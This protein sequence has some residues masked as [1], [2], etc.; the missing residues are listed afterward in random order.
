MFLL[1]GAGAIC[2]RGLGLKGRLPAR[3]VRPGDCTT[4][5]ANV[6][7][8]AHV[9]ERSANGAR[10]PRIGN[11]GIVPPVAN[12][13][14]PSPRDPCVPP[15]P[16][17]PVPPGPA[18]GAQCVVDRGPP[19]VQSGTRS[20]CGPLVCTV[21]VPLFDLGCCPRARWEAPPPISQVI[22]RRVPTTKSDGGNGTQGPVGSGSPSV[23][24]R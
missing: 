5:P 17:P 10:G 15:P 18:P 6:G 8:V 4:N 2:C 9:F 22:P 21:H 12:P 3:S 11:I 13:Q 16:P 14:G 19:P 7:A 1:G 20:Q 24:R 23:T